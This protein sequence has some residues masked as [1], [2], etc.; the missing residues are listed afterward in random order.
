MKITNN[1]NVQ[2]ILGVYQKKSEGMEK[3]SKFKQE[4][5]KVE[6]SEQARAFQ[7]A[8]S[9]YKKL[10]DI[11]KD[12]VNE[13]CRQIQSGSYHPSAEEIVERILDRRI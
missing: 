3:A 12:K 5:D 4:K 13:V 2:K 9:A 6:I 1:S 10:P 11:R 8:L 7:V